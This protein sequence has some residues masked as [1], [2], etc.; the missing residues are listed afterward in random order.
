MLRF[1]PGLGWL[2]CVLAYRWHLKVTLEEAFPTFRFIRRDAPV[3]YTSLAY[4]DRHTLNLALIPD[5]P[6]INAGDPSNCP[7]TDQR[8]Q[9]RKDRCDIGAFQLEDR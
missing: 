1:D 8:C 7:E 4:N 3:I 5:S 6:A 9:P 2:S